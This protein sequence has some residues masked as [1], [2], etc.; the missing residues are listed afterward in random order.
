MRTFIA[1]HAPASGPL[2]R[3]LGL[4]SGWRGLKVVSSQQLHLTLKFL[5]ETDRSA[6]ERLSDLV[7]EGAARVVRQEV[8]YR[9]LGAFPREDRP[10]VVWVGLGDP[11]PWASLAEW[12]DERCGALGFSREARAW[13]PHVTLARVKSR[14]ADELFELIHDQRS[15]EL[16][17][18]PFTA[19]TLYHSE[20]LPG[21]PVYTP[22][23]SAPL[24][25]SPVVTLPSEVASLQAEVR[26]PD[27]SLPE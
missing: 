18:A 5:G 9:G 4:M 19:L 3:V 6:L 1:I 14:P 26:P 17:S 13:T 12:L 8:T 15:A 27:S 11:L 10:S 23:C 20:L 25:E 22:V 21:G 24:A 7:R 16:G 2:E